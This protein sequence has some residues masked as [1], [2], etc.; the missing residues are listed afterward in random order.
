MVVPPVI[1]HFDG[2]FHYK[3]S[4][5]GYLDLWNH[6]YNDGITHKHP[7]MNGNSHTELVWLPS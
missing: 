1:I 6:P 5:L 4:M 2:I 7:D 3:P